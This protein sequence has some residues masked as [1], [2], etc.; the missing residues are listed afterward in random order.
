MTVSN[1]PGLVKAILKCVFSDILL[2][3]VLDADQNQSHALLVS[4]SLLF[5]PDVHPN[6]QKTRRL[7][8][9]CPVEI[10][11]LT[12]ILNTDS[13][14]TLTKLCCITVTDSHRHRRTVLFCF[15]FL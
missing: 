7:N 13:E 12:S 2:I 14:E 1:G 8:L 10:G 11:P 9:I 6:E 15:L 3:E 5:G 4:A